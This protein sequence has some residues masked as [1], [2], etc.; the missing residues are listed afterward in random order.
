MQLVARWTLYGVLACLLVLVVTGCKA[1]PY[2]P[3]GNDLWR[4][5]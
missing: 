3:P 4:L 2:Q 1:N 5:V